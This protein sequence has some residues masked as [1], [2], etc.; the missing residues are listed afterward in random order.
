M[1]NLMKKI[2][3]ETH[4]FTKEYLKTLSENKGYPRFV[5]GD[6]ERKHR[7]WHTD[8]VG[9]PYGDF[10]LNPLLDLGEGRIKMMDSVGIDVQVLSLSAPGI[11][12]LDPEIGKSLA[13]ASNDALSAAIGKYPDRLKGFAALAPNA[14]EEAAD[15]LERAVK[16][17]GFIGWNTHS[18]FGDSYL[19]EEKYWPILE[20][21]EK[22]DAPIY[23]HPTIPAMTPMKKFGFPL[24]GAP[25]G[26]GVDAALCMMRLIYSGVFDTYPKLKIILGHLGEALPFLLKRIDW[27]YVRPLDPSD[28]PTIGKKPSEY[29]QNNVFVTT[30][31]NYYEPA[32]MCTR[33]ALGIDRILLATDFP[34]EDQNECLDFI[35]QLPIP[36]QEKEKVYFKNAAQ[37]GISI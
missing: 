34:Y 23:L 14:P 15:E 31:G 3:F 13:K 7:L 11:E 18:N 2:D 29:L 28:R 8:D 4:F 16:E 21:A 37:L 19:D 25:F 17:L 33:A 20:R 26:F 22:L 6:G 5:E 24:A 9:Q 30:S 1:E 36:E 12:K 27:A 32:F 10:L 35:E